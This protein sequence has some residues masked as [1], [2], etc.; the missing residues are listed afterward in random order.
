M[1]PTQSSVGCHWCAWIIVGCHCFG[2]CYG[3]GGWDT[4]YIFWGKILCH[5]GEYVAY[6]NDD[7]GETN[8]DALKGIGQLVMCACRA[9]T[10]INEECIDIA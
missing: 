6:I 10:H 9:H 4:F 5:I 8:H 3:E 7:G 2:K 1:T